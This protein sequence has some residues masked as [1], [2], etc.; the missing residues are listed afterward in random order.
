[1]EKILTLTDYRQ[2]LDRYWRAGRMVMENKQTGKST[3]MPW[4][5]YKF[6]VGLAPKDFT[7][8]RLKSKSI[9]R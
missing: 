1:M 7:K 6:R 3:E 2:Y 8:Q 5:N 9:A 4:T